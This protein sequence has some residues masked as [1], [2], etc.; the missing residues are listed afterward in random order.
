MGTRIPVVAHDHTSFLRKVN[1]SVDFTRYHLYGT[2]DV[3]VILTQRDNKALGKK[4]PQKRVIYNPLPFGLASA[5]SRHRRKSI[6]CVGRFDVWQVKGFDI[7]V[8]V[9][10]RLSKIHTDW[11]LEFAGCGTDQSMEIIRK[12]VEEKGIKNRVVFHG[13]V[14]DMQE[15]YRKVQIF[16]LPSRVEGLPMGLMEAMS[17]GCACV[18]FE[19]G[20][21]TNEMITQ[22]TSGYYVKDGDVVDFECKLDL[23]M[24][25]ERASDAMGH[26]AIIESAKFSLDNVMK[27]WN[28]L[29]NN[30]CNKKR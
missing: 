8:E 26:N 24:S 22:G 13:Q 29:L 5:P 20:G 21:A 17:Q 23:L 18:A 27:D 28:D 7:I 19:V 3:V 4:Y 1:K 14:S 10:A 6:L 11:N 25:D 12:M 9:F 15:L 2:S 30:L 16:A